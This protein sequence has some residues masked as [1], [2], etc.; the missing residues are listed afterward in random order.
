MKG[1]P[2]HFTSVLQLL[3]FTSSRGWTWHNQHMHDW[4]AGF[5][6]PCVLY[7]TLWVP[8]K[9]P[10]RHC[11]LF[12]LVF[13]GSYAPLDGHFCCIA[14]LVCDH[15][16]FAPILFSKGSDGW[17][18]ALTIFHI[19]ILDMKAMKALA[20]FLTQSGV[21]STQYCSSHLFNFWLCL[22][23]TGTLQEIGQL[24]SSRPLFQILQSSAVPVILSDC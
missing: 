18:K 21:D 2:W 23:I 16:L 19:S 17:G 5:L 20:I 8:L 22:W 1:H 7:P 9:I 6:A 12:V 14:Y 10:Q 24:V 15:C 11:F 4:L 3:C 13:R